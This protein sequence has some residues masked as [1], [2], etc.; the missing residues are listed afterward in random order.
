MPLSSNTIIHLTHQKSSL[1]GILERNFRIHYCKETILLHDEEFVMRVPMVSFCDIP[2]S[3]IKE[4]IEKYGCYGIGLSKSWAERNG[5]NPVLYIEPKSY[6]SKS[7]SKA[8][9][10]LIVD[11]PGDGLSDGQQCFI[12]ILRY[13]KNYQGQLLRQGRLIDEYRFSDEREWRYVPPLTELRPMLITEK[14]YQKNKDSIPLSPQGAV[15]RFEPNDIKYIIIESDS[16]IPEFLNLL[17]QTKGKIYTHE[18]VERLMTRILTAEQI[19][20]DI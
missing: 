4:H 17:R 16:E 9:Q 11:A 5:L 1:K 8:L 12:D 7:Y 3:E 20:E 18:D 19:K 15:L 13:I 2:L 6:L 10:E 14:E